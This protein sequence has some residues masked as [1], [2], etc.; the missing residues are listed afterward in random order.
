MS[1]GGVVVVASHD[2]ILVALSI[3]ISII[4]AYVARGL[5][6][7]IDENRGRS[8]LPWLAGAA[9]ADGV[10]TWSMH[11]TG[12]LALLLP[13]PLRFD[14][15]LVLLSLLISIAG[16][17]LAL[18]IAS[19]RTVRKR[20]AIG[21]GAVM[22]I[23]AISG[24][25]FIAMAAMWLP[26]MHHRYRSP[27]LVLL[28]IVAAVVISSQAVYLRS[29]LPRGGRT[30][31]WR[32]HAIAWLR[33]TANPV[34]HYTAMAAVVF[35]YDD[36][37]H[38]RPDGVSGV[39]L[40]IMAITVVPAM[41]LIAALLTSFVDRL[42]KQKVLLDELFEQ[43]PQPVALM[44]ADEL[45]VRVNREFTRV[46]G[47]APE[48]AKDRTL[49][50]LIG[51]EDA[52]G[53]HRRKDGSPVC[54]S[55]LRVPVSIPGGQVEIYAMLS[56]VTARRKSEE[57]QR[58]YPRRLL[59]AQEAVGKR[60]A[61]ELHD[62]IGQTLTSVGM[63]LAL[64][65]KLE[66]AEADARITDARSILHDMTARVRNLA[67]D[68]RPSILDDFGLVAA[69]QWLIQRYSR[70]TNVAVEFNS[71]MEG[72]R[73]PPDVE[74]AAYRIV[75]EALTN[76]ARHAGETEVTVRLSLADDVLRVEIA[77]GGIGFDSENVNSSVGVTGMQERAR[78][79]GGRLTIATR[80]GVGTRITAELPIR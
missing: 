38:H 9:V 60:I 71:T 8:W 6:E 30:G 58:E 12:K 14:G 63:M 16:S 61:L 59:E 73:L 19:R 54:V 5:A 24:L 77:D 44:T 33:G 25:H 22:G 4:A 2:P 15:R 3:G 51:P 37:M 11:Y 50:E 28:S 10:G 56:D 66:R 78:I 1:D 32:R 43:S 21:A 13:V 52:K 45:I 80:P 74:I 23:V 79:L 34:M 35:V 53:V 64:T 26:G 57:A 76:V 55:I 18:W 7:R 67:L 41:V 65:P 69:L 70:Q 68:L 39:T 29:L 20:H 46:F 62:E 75:Q 72:E 49:T 40:G 27:A 17:G 48:E 47:Y 42:Q 31:R 36:T